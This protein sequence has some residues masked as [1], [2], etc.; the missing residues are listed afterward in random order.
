MAFLNH[1][2]PFYPA[3]DSTLPPYANGTTVLDHVRSAY[4]HLQN[5]IG[6]GPHGLLRILEGDWDDGVVFTDP[7]PL[8]V[9]FT[10]EHGES[11]PNSQ[12]AIQVLPILASIIEPYDPQLASDM[13]QL[14]A[15]LV[16]P[17]ARVFGT[18]YVFVAH[19][20]SLSE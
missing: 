5:V 4:Y 17:V 6:T 3:S 11:I 2:L 18:K 1:S 12:M 14:A 7:D 19:T 9:L 10:I 13:Q 8:A 16:Q 20:H 15:S